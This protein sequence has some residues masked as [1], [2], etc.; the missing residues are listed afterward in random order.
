VLKPASVTITCAAFFSRHPK[1]TSGNCNRKPGCPERG[2]RDQHPYALPPVVPAD[3]AKAPP[4]PPRGRLVGLL[5]GDHAI[6]A[7]VA[8]GAAAASET[9]PRIIVRR[10]FTRSVEIFAW[11]DAQASD[12]MERE[13]RRSTAAPFALRPPPTA[14]VPPAVTSG[15]SVGAIAPADRPVLGVEDPL[16]RFTHLH[17]PHGFN[18]LSPSQRDAGDCT[19]G[20]AKTERSQRKIAGPAM[21]RLFL[22]AFQQ[23]SVVPD[24]SAS[25]RPSSDSA[26]IDPHHGPHRRAGRPTECRDEWLPGAPD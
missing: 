1:T 26:G 24:A 13:R 9:P 16:A 19:Q 5:G 20:V 11:P 12:R 25:V 23:F 3:G 7:D 21:L 14:A 22:S 17:T 15:V 4:L 18:S 8:D 2:P 6:V 10:E